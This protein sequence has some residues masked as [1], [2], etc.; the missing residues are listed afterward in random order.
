[1][2]IALNFPVRLVIRFVRAVEQLAHDYHAVH[3]AELTPVTA[4][5]EPIEFFYQSDKK[6]YEQEREE[7]FR[8]MVAEEGL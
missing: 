7:K 1:M 5:D 4:S 2:N 8:R 6:L 3:A